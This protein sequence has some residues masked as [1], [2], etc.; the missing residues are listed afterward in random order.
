LKTEFGDDSFLFVS[1]WNTVDYKKDGSDDASEQQEASFVNFVRYFDVQFNE[2]Q[3][4][5]NM[6]VC[7]QFK[8]RMNG[9]VFSSSWKLTG[10]WVFG[11]APEYP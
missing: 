11:Q 10:K 4:P 7:G 9:L 1:S 3:V 8:R 6:G 2:G 5:K